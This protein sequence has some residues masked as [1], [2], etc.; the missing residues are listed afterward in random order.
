MSEVTSG[1][2]L[3]STL[4]NGSVLE[5]TTLKY[6]NDRQSKTKSETMIGKKINENYVD[7]ALE[8]IRLRC[9][10][11]LEYKE[12]AKRLG[13]SE[14]VVAWAMRATTLKKY[15]LDQHVSDVKQV[16]SELRKSEAR[17]L[18]HRRAYKQGAHRESGPGWWGKRIYRQDGKW[19]AICD[20][21]GEHIIKKE[22]DVNHD[23]KTI[24]CRGCLCGTKSGEKI[25]AESVL[26]PMR[27]NGIGDV[28]GPLWIV[29]RTKRG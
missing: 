13:V 16:N 26:S 25:D 5:N 22:C 15:G 29:P 24:L 6:C 1:A 27:N 23:K 3:L 9:S 4:T 20:D 10:E 18:V 17:R 21:C 28:T 19:F 7:R 8:M 11:R 2:V 12:I 14:A